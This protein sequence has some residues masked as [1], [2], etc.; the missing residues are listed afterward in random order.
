MNSVKEFYEIALNYCD[1][2]SKKRICA[3]TYKEYMEILMRIYTAA[4][5][6]PNVEPDTLDSLDE[7]SINEK[8]PITDPLFY[9]EVFDPFDRDD[10]PV[11]SSVYED[12]I[13]IAEALHVG[14]LEYEAGRINNAAWE[15]RC[16]VN[17]HYGRHLV[18]CLR[19]LHFLRVNEE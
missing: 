19:A 11:C 10:E 1:V 15:W 5:N 2:V 13:S 12:I 6:I 7:N 14:I 3:D 8:I 9:Y 18:D 4:L 16:G 17:A